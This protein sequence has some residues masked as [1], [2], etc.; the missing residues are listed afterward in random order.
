MAEKEPLSGWDLSGFYDGVL[1]RWLPPTNKYGL[2]PSAPQSGGMVSTFNNGFE[3]HPL[4]PVEAY[5]KT[6]DP[7]STWDSPNEFFET[8]LATVREKTEGPLISPQTVFV[9]KAAP[10]IW[11][12]ALAGALVLFFI[13]KKG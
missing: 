3:V 10:P 2:E 6:F 7:T 9:E 13:F 11:P 5:A 8:D 4:P 1:T 12:M